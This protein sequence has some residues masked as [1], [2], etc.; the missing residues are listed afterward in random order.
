MSEIQ[1]VFVVLQQFEDAPECE[2][3]IIKAEVITPLLVTAEEYSEKM[4]SI[5][6]DYD[7]FE[8]LTEASFRFGVCEI[9]GHLNVYC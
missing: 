6:M 1:K 9:V 3:W 2:A 7:D 8:I 4:Y 5:S